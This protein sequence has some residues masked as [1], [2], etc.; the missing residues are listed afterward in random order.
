MRR[1]RRRVR[2]SRGGDRRRTRPNS[3]E[4]IATNGDSSYRRRKGSNSPRPTVTNGDSGLRRRRS[5]VSSHS[6]R[7]G[8]RMSSGRCCDR[9][10]KLPDQ[11]PAWVPKWFDY[12][13][14]ASGKVGS[15]AVKG[16]F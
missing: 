11:V 14:V 4:P 9:K 5:F 15:G 10:E 1:R 7:V 16:G 13:Q 12:Y 8:Y 6:A 2:R 3:S